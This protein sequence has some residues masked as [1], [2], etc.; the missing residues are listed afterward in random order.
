MTPQQEQ[1]GTGPPEV[2]PRPLTHREE[3]VLVALIT[4]GAWAGDDGVVLTTDDRAR[5]LAQVPT[6]RAG[7]RC[8]CGTCPS[9]ELTDTAG[10][11]PDAGDGRVVLQAGASG[12]TLLLF[13]DEDRL[14]YLE[15][16]PDASAF[17]DFPDPQEL[18]LLE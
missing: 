12:A 4:R 7:R 15:L 9:I 16:A 6:T 14:S 3:A 5:W 1:P 18:N 13:V 2:A 8:T 17:H 10:W 11:R